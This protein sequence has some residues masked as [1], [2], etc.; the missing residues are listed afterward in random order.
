[1]GGLVVAGVVLVGLVVWC[2]ATGAAWAWMVR[3]VRRAGVHLVEFIRARLD[4][5]EAA[6]RAA[7]T[8][9]PWDDGYESFDELA[10]GMLVGDG[11]ASVND[12]HT[13][14]ARPIVV[15][16]EEWTYPPHGFELVEHIARHDP[17]RVLREVEAKRRILDEVHPNF[18]AA[19][20]E[21]GVISGGP[22]LLLR[23]L[24]ALY[25]DHPDYRDGWRP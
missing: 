1:M 13:L 14:G 17:A 11:Q 3:R 15:V 9:H 4:E 8:K 2:V 7:Q 20:E 16:Q 18:E 6:A 22:D 25:V 24:A 12:G 23:L 5:D 19:E 21:A 10:N